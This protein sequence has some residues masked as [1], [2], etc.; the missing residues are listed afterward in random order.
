MKMRV[1]HTKNLREA[2]SVWRID[3]GNNYLYQVRRK[4]LK[5]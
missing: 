2:G 5:H 1:Q 3:Y 4:V